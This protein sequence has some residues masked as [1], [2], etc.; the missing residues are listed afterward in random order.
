RDAEALAG[1][2]EKFIQNPELI[3][4]MGAQSRKIAEDKYDVHKV[5]K[6]ILSAMGL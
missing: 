2:M 3:G 4:Q 5:N 1:A 6:V